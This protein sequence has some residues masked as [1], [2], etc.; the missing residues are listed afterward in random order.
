MPTFML[1]ELFY[2]QKLGNSMIHSVSSSAFLVDSNFTRPSVFYKI[3]ICTYKK[4]RDQEREVGHYRNRKRVSEDN[5]KNATYLQLFDK[6][7]VQI[8]S[9]I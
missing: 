7:S 9:Q 2:E 4:E 3:F 1:I 8:K 5:F 6:T